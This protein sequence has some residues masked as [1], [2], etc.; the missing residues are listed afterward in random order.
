MIALLAASVAPA[1]AAAPPRSPAATA[2][3]AFATPAAALAAIA[4]AEDRRDWADHTLERALAHPDAAVRARALLAV[5]R[6]QDSTTVRAV[7][8]LL[9]DTSAGVRREAVFA[10]GQIGHPSARLPLERLLGGADI[11][12]VDLALEALGKIGSKAST[13]LVAGYL[14]DPSPLLRGEAAIALW[15]LADSTALDALIERH[16]D[17]DPE[18]RWRVLYALEKIN[19][20][21]QI[22]LIG[23][24]HLEDDEWLSRAYAARTL[25]R[26]KSARA[27]A[28]LLQKLADPEVPVV[29][30]A[31]RALQQI[32]DSACSSC[33]PSLANA[34]SHAHP[35]VRVTVATALGE[36]FAWVS[37]DTVAVRSALGALRDHLRDPDAATRGACAAALLGRRG[38]DG[39]DA[40]RPLLADSSV[41]A[42]AAALR[43]L[44][45]VRVALAAPLLESRLDVEHALFERMTAAE[46]L[47]QI[48]HRESAALLRAGLADSATL[49]V[50]SC[51]GALADLGD[52][53]SVPI[54]VRAFAAR[55]ADADADARISIRDALRQ[56]AGARLADSLD[57]VFPA[58]GALPASYP[59][60]FAT[61]P[62][63]RGALIHTTAGDI[64]WAFYGREAPQTVK[65]FVRLAARGYFD[66]AAVHR[67]VP[68]FV[69]QDGDPTG[70]GSGGPGY[71][72]R[73][74]YNRLR[75]DAGM[76]GMALSGKDTGGSQ[77]FITHSP[78][79]HLDGR[80]TIFAQVV[81]GMA[82]VDQLEPKDR[83][84]RAVLIP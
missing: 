28:Y 11:E 84:L 72:I 65:N 60:D 53:A 57:R 15:R 66:G 68:N 83:I 23:A 1:R 7:L 18:V 22:A 14:R 42:R 55:A 64:E 56:L 40:V 62:A 71:S 38:A 33:L 61:P 4:R 21:D 47:G 48:H 45:R 78:Q 34:L 39:L 79:H 59:D 12:T 82:V 10:L 80:Y 29:V 2:A 31:V 3:P 81:E 73:C 52:S 58:R 30:N 51:A 32:A 37:A 63:Q 75:Y 67:V 9:A 54:L 5:G 26:Q 49:F 13:A 69:I 6:L 50:A 77:W 44:G 70:T 36:R 19:A 76:V 17:P 74:E 8:P 46:E 27:T 20:P 16:R 24:L 41:Y 43:A 25:G 35:Y